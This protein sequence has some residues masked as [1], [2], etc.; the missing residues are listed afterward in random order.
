MVPTFF[1]YKGYELTFADELIRT[2][3]NAQTYDE[4]LDKLRAAF[5]ACLR[6]GENLLVDCGKGSIDFT[7]KW[8]RPDVFDTKIFFDWDLGHK[9]ENY[10]KIVKDHENHGLGGINPGHYYHHEKFSMTFCSGGD[11]A[12][13]A[14]LVS[15]IPHSAKMRK[16]IIT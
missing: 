3:M 13:I 15:L 11:D 7:A 8:T 2:A 9:R 1:R 4:S 12:E 5:V 10:M 16:I 6:N 14:E